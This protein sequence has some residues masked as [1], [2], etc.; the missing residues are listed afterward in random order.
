MTY[1]RPD[2]SEGFWYLTALDTNIG[3]SRN[4]VTEN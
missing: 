1:Y 3:M 2:D 4:Y